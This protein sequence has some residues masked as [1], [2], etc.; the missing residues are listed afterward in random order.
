VNEEI[1]SDFL[2]IFIFQATK[3]ETGWDKFTVLSAKVCHNS[4]YA[5]KLLAAVN[6]AK[7]D[8]PWRTTR[9]K[10]YHPVSMNL[11]VKKP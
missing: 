9:D 1:Y 10:Y 6:I 7:P 2:M 11:V 3:L 8:E 4:E 5:K